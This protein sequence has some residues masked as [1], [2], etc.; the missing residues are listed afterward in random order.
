MK[1][2]EFI[3]DQVDG[4]HYKCN[5]ISLNRGGLYINSHDEI[6]CKK[7]IIKPKN[8]HYKCFQYAITTALNHEWIQKYL[9]G[10][11]KIKPFIIQHE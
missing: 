9:Q 8:S 3:F 2:T 10:I 1:G 4:L 11:T 5:G 6:K 7:T